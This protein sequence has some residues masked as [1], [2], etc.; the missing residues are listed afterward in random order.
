MGQIFFVEHQGQ[1]HKVDLKTGQTLMALAIENNIPGIDADC[2]GECACGTCHVKLEQ[3]WFGVVNKAEA[4]ELQMLDMT[5]ER[6]DTSRLSC[7][8][9][10]TEE[11]NGMVVQLPEFQM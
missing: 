9:Q 8:I 7:R 11:L 2:G 3:K 6:A 5:P 1:V 4:D 10:I